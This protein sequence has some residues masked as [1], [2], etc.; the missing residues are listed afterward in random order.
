MNC[1]AASK[2]SISGM[3]SSRT[4]AFTLSLI[5]VCAALVRGDMHVW[6]SVRGV[7]Q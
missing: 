2:L 1:F 6:R 5:S 3:S 7:N 4:W